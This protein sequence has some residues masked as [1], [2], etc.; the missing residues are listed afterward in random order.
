MEDECHLIWG[1]TLGHVWGKRNKQIAVSMLNQRE[2]QTYYGAVDILTGE[3]YIV[4]LATGNGKNTVEYVKYL[5]KILNNKKIMI[6]WD[7]ASYHRFAEMRE[8]LQEV[9]NNLPPEEWVITCEL[10]AP[11]APEQNPVE[12]IWLKGKNHLRKV[13]AEN[14][15][16][17]KVKKSFINYYQNMR[18]DFHKIQLYRS[19]IL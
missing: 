15:T 4:P 16:F 11:N 18:F 17:A 13:F 10:F 14:S 7:G 1:D 5:Q 2:R 19:Y 6:I 3:F 12:D 8:Y 9:N